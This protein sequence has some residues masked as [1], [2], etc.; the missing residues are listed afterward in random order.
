MTQPGH[1]EYG[2]VLMSSI[3][4]ARGR[5]AAIRI[6][7]ETF[8]AFFYEDEERNVW[9]T[10]TGVIIHKAIEITANRNGPFSRV[11]PSPIPFQAIHRA[12]GA[13][14]VVTTIA[15]AVQRAFTNP[16]LIAITDTKK[17][18]EAAYHLAAEA[19]IVICRDWT[20]PHDKAAIS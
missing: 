3:H 19:M 4:S 15:R 2:R 14:W 10:A 20:S 12:N 17:Q 6:L 8:P 5:R 18:E 13:E 9:A 1:D 16:V 11:Y 7:Q